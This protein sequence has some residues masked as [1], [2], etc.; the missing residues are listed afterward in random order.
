MMMTT[1]TV[2]EALLEVQ[3]HDLAV[4][5]LRHRRATLSERRSLEELAQT[6]ARVDRRLASVVERAAELRGR[7]RRLEDEIASLEERRSASQERLYGG[8]VQAPREL[9]ALA[10]EV[11]A[12]ARRARELEDEL[13]ELM[14]AAEPIEHEQG[15]L[16]GQRRQL[17]AEVARLGVV[18]AGHEAEIDAVMASEVSKRAQVAAGI[19]DELLATYERLRRRLDGIGVAR[20]EGGRCTGCHLALPAVEL[21][22]VR[23]ASP[24]A[25]V[26]HEECGRILV[27]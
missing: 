24:G 10:S 14:E 1:D 21:D 22:A 12:L 3:A 13:L 20:L 2:L 11:E 15:S 23:R 26:R 5:Q 9:Q 6:S 7:Q 8:T 27:T 19:P 18:V 4:D 25:V 17:D 16:E